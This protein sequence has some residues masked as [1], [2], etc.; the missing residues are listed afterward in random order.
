MDWMPWVS[1]LTLHG[2]RGLVPLLGAE[3][4]PSLESFRLTCLSAR[5]APMV[6]FGSG[7]E[8]VTHVVL[9]VEREGEPEFW[10]RGGSKVGGWVGLVGTPPPPKETLSC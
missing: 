6:M 8:L 4:T 2:Y 3:C 5:S 9:S 7:Q 10:L 1:W